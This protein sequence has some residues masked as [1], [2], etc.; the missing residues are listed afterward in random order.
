MP[1]LATL[2]SDA[3]QPIVSEPSDVGDAFASFHQVFDLSV[4]L[5][6][7]LVAGGLEL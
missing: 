5:A 6:T 7:A 1:H 3:Q 4:D 2:L